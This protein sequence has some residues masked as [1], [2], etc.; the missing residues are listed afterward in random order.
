MSFN[1]TRIDLRMYLKLSI[2]LEI[3]IISCEIERQMIIYKSDSL[4]PADDNHR[5]PPGLID[6]YFTVEKL[7]F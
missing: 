7:I 5:L 6:Y 3:V 2:V 1:L 4:S